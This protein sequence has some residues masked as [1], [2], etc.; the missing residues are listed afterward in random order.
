VPKWIREHI[1]AFFT[2]TAAA[3]AA[4]ITTVVCVSA[5]DIGHRRRKRL[6]SELRGEDG[7]E[8]VLGER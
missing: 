7:S 1:D 2:D 8:Y 3:A 6:K 5:D 4:A